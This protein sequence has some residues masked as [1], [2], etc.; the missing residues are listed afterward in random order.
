M[1]ENLPAN[2]GNTGSIPGLGRSLGKGNGNLIQYSC[3]GN[4]MDRGP[5]QTLESMGWQRVRHSLVTKQQ[6]IYNKD[7]ESLIFGLALFQP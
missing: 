3:L 1:V 7:S 4:P 5:W 2:A 6:Q